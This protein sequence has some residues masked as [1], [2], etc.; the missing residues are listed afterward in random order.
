MEDGGKNRV[1]DGERE[2]RRKG[3]SREGQRRRNE[4]MK[5]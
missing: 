5:E 1:R 3:E 4:G 2:D